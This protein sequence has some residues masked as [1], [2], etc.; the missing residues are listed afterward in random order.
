M[1]GQPPLRLRSGQAVGCSGR[2]KLDCLLRGVYLDGL[3]AFGPRTADGGCPHM[4]LMKVL[5]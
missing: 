2:A 3:R 1:W 4:R 5:R